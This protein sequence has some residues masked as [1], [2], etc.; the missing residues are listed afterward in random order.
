MSPDFSMYFDVEYQRN[1]FVIRD[2][3]D[4]SIKFSLSKYFTSN[5]LSTESNVIEQL[6][7]LAWKDNDT[8]RVIDYQNPDAIEKLLSISKSQ[9]SGFT[10]EISSSS[11]PYL[12]HD[13]YKVSHQGYRAGNYFKDYLPSD[14]S[15]V[16]FRL[17]Q[18]HQAL[19]TVS[20][21]DY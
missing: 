13:L 16:E 9:K 10:E 4:G 11:V 12:D 1:E 17:K 5:D 20:Y 3:L 8:I 18:N 2:T 19:K 6:K 14:I 21:V 15:D 7:F